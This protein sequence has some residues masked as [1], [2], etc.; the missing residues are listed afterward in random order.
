MASPNADWSLHG[1]TAPRFEEH[2]RRLI[3]R[4]VDPH[5][6]T[7]S[8]SEPYNVHDVADDLEEAHGVDPAVA[9]RIGALLSAPPAASP[10]GASR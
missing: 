9:R 6:E 1:M 7:F 3:A 4:G 10:T 2:V 8:E 5:L